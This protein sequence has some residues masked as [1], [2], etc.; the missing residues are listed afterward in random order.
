MNFKN[1]WL[2]V[3]RECNMR[4]QWCYGKTMEFSSN[5]VMGREVAAQLIDFFKELSLKKVILIGGEPTVHPQFLEIVSM[6]KSAGM[7][8]VLVTN[9]VKFAD[10]GFLKESLLAGLDGIT[11][12]L[13]ASSGEQYA[14]LTGVDAFTDVMQAI[15]NIEE[16]GVAHNVVVTVCGSMFEKFE[17]MIEVVI[18]S[19]AKS[20]TLDM[21]RPII[22]NN[23]VQFSG[24]TSPQQMAD[25]FTAMYPKVSSLENITTSIIMTLPFCLFPS[26]LIDEMKE[27][28]QLTSSC[29][30]LKGSG[31]IM[32]TDGRLLPC[33]Q[34]CDN[35]LGE[36]GIDF[37]NAEEFLA[38][39]ERDEVRNFYKD[40]SSCPHEKCVNCPQ[41]KF[42][43]AGCRMH[44]LYWDASMLLGNKK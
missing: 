31:I 7:R 28:N 33:N 22:V 14:D 17:E 38:F 36:F 19:G 27:K 41:W 13:K 35:P 21:E 37:K 16:T 12:S 6:I 20:L 10:K 34:F 40:V 26:K 11:T 25:F 32:D 5:A 4:C 42:C 43:G 29:Q 15:A 2:T 1:A 18:K 23:E 9:G 24:S 30:L 44:W 39:R 8:P 3:N